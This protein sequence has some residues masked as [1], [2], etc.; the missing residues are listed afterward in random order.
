MNE[1]R[2]D[3]AGD[4]DRIIDFRDSIMVANVVATV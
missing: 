2:D 4:G 1:A 3:L